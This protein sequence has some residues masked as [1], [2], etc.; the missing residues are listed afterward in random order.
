[1]KYVLLLLL[2]VNSSEAG[3]MRGL[4]QC[5]PSPSCQNF[6]ILDKCPSPL[7]PQQEDKFLMIPQLE[8]EE[9]GRGVP[10]ESISDMPPTGHSVGFLETPSFNQILNYTLNDNDF[11]GS[12]LRRFG[13]PLLIYQSKTEIVFNMSDPDCCFPWKVN[14]CDDT[15]FRLCHDDPIF[16]LPP[17]NHVI[18]PA[19]PSIVLMAFGGLLLTGFYLRKSS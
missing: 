14:K 1:M 12:G 17:S 10:W 18:V 19:P 13:N 8:E 2:F 5:Q 16:N 4:K 11:G 15:K 7:L 6:I 9:G 3:F